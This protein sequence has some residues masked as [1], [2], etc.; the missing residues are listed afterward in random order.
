MGAFEI[1]GYTSISSAQSYVCE[2]VLS[3]TEFAA[4]ARLFLGENG[5]G[6]NARQRAFIAERYLA[7]LNGYL[8]IHVALHQPSEGLGG[9]SGQLNNG[10]VAKAAQLILVLLQPYRHGAGTIGV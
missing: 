4:G 1:N 2:R 3:S 8:I 10:E 7:I 6:G 5:I 9:F